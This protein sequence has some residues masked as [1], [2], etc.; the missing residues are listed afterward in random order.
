MSEIKKLSDVFSYI[1]SGEYVGERAW[2]MRDVEV[3]V[4]YST[5]ENTFGY[6]I[7]PWF[8]KHKNVFFW[9]ELVNGYAVAMNENPSRGLFFP[10]IKIRKS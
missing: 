7:R 10:V 8:G 4:E 2:Q 6:P 9:V 5:T 3:K 1:L